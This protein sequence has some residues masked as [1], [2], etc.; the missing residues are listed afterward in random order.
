MLPLTKLATKKHVVTGLRQKSVKLHVSVKEICFIAFQNFSAVHSIVAFFNG[1]TQ[2]PADPL[3][4]T[5]Y[6]ILHT[7]P[8]P[9]QPPPTQPHSH[10][11]INRMTGYG[12]RKPVLGP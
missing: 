1:M 6:Y 2:Y 9:P 3:L 10:T 4:H 7:K 11:F 12:L 5:I 8:L